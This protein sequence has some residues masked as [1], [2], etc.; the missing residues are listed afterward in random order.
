MKK[1]LMALGGL[2]LI[3]ALFFAFKP[4]PD[5]PETNSVQTVESQDNKAEVQ[6]AKQKMR[7]EFRESQKKKNEECDAMVDPEKKG[8]CMKELRDGVE[9]FRNK[10]RKEFNLGKPE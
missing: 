1:A 8:I 6:E 7:M 10:M 4:S 3:V 9:I 5:S 2:I